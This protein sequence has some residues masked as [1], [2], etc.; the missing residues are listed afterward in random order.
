MKYYI[1]INRG[2]SVTFSYAIAGNKVICT[3]Q[4]EDGEDF[5]T[6]END[7]KIIIYKDAPLRSCTIALQSLGA[8]SFRKIIEVA[9]GMELDSMPQSIREVILSDVKSTF[10]IT[11]SDY[12]LIVDAMLSSINPK[13]QEDMRNP[14]NNNVLQQI[15]YGAPGTGKS[16]Q[17]KEDIS[18]SPHFRT[19]FHPDSD[20]SSF[21]GAYKPT[22]TKIDVR[23]VTGKVIIENG[24]KV[25]EDKI[26]YKY[27]AQSFLEAYIAAWK[28]YPQ[29]QYL[30][31]EEINRGNCAQIF[32]DLFQLLDRNSKGFSDYPIQADNDI[33]QHINSKLLGIELSD[34]DKNI[35][36]TIFA[37]E[38]KNVVEKIIDGEVLLL[39]SNLY[40]WATMNTSDQSLFPIDSAFK[41]RWDWKYIPISNANKGWIISTNGYKYEWWSFLEKINDK[42]GSTTDSE[43]KKL[44]YFFVKADDSKC[45]TA[46][47]FVGKVIFYLWNDVFKDYGFDDPIFKDADDDDILSFQKFFNP[48]GKANVAKVEMFLDN[49]GVTKKEI[50]NDYNEYSEEEDNDLDS[51][52]SSSKKLIVT[53]DDGFECS[54]KYQF[55][56]YLMALKKMDFAKICPIAQ[57]MNYT[58][59]ECPL[60]DTEK[61]SNIV[62]SS[63]YNYIDADGY[64][65][66]KGINQRT[67]VNVLNYLS[68]KLGISI[69][70]KL[71]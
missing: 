27:V 67:M 43:D 48:N 46:D 25:K 23:D 19:T 22:M 57:H 4:K 28:H 33:R 14:S 34:I 52:E 71:L 9:N 66:V 38:Y 15:I 16:H 32:G 21:V 6:F 54:G 61:K 2:A 41:R 63:D 44:G 64:Y 11:E 40:I 69:D 55:D 70:V 49:L 31:I 7:D 51:T 37:K 18:N 58:R 35:I 42:I 17:I 20:Y 8:N 29:K 65:V 3:S 10:E 1:W 47:K 53:F 39:P 62:N 68:G 5:P 13:K 59:K 45:I 56:S 30:I 50:A 24:D 12:A 26:V 60:I 36:N